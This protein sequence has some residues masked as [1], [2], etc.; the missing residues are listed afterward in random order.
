MRAWLLVV[1]SA[2]LLL[3][4]CGD[5][6]QSSEAEHAL[7]VASALENPVFR[8]AAL[9]TWLAD[10]PAAHEVDR[11]DALNEIWI[12]HRN[13]LEETAGLAWARAELLDEPS[14]LGKSVLYSLLFATAVESGSKETAIQIAQEVWD[15]GIT[16]AETLNRLGWA[17]VAD[18]GWDLDLGTRLAER[19]VEFAEPGPGK[20]SIMDTAGWGYF[21]QGKKEPTQALLE[22]A[23]AELPELDREITGHLT[24]F[25]E[26]IGEEIKLLHLWTRMLHGQ[27]DRDLQAKAEILHKKRGGSV[28]RYRE[29]L[30]EMRMEKADSAPDFELKDLDGVEYRLS[31]YRG[32][33]VMLNF[34]HPT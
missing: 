18:P 2:A 21:L 7:A 29:K 13:R 25:Y 10:Y 17:L 15:E 5:K 23:M 14:M 12:I 11:A 30:W 27:M 31:D 20:A 28:E 3:A 9:Q 6:D 19:G 8:M 4:A 16:H 24:Q 32:K 1:F 33:V 26:R 22:G 34:W